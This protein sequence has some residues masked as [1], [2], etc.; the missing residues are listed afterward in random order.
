M[1]KE[2]LLPQ[3]D[4]IMDEIAEEAGT[5]VVQVDNRSVHLLWPKTRSDGTEVMKHIK[6]LVQ[7]AITI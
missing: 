1:G 2:V 5:A 3:M 6:M 4:T 7:Y